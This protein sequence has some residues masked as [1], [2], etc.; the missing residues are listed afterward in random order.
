MAAWPTST[1]ELQTVTVNEGYAALDPATLTAY[2]I[3]VDTMLFDGRAFVTTDNQQG[4]P[5]GH[6]RHVVNLVIIDNTGRWRIEPIGAITAEAD[7]VRARSLAQRL[8]GLVAAGLV[9]DQIQ[10]GQDVALARAVSRGT[11]RF[12][13][14]DG[15]DAY[16]WDLSE[17]GEWTHNGTVVQP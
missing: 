8:G 14:V 3:T 1:R 12:D 6:H 17:S 15:F 10:T 5:A 2:G 4:L 11:G 16:G 13:N 9:P 7:L